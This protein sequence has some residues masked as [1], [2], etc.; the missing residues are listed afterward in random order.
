MNISTILQNYCDRYHVPGLSVAA[1]RDG[2]TLWATG[3]GRANLEW[4]IPATAETVYEI[5]S[6][7]KLFTA[8]AVLRLA[9][10][11][12]LGLDDALHDHLPHLPEAWRGVTIRHCLAHQSGL[13]SYTATE[14]YWQTTRLDVSREELLGYV[15]DLPLL[16]PPGQRYHYDNTGF[17]LLGLLIEQVSGQSY[18]DFVAAQILRPLG[19]AD[20]RANDPY[21]IVSR[22]AQGYSYDAEQAAVRHKPYYSPTGTYSAGVLLSTVADLAKF[23]C[24]LESDAWLS[25]A[26][27]Q[28]MRTIHPSAEANERQL[29][30][31][32]GLGWFFVDHP[33]GRFMG[34]NGGI[35]GFASSFIHLLNDGLTLILLCN[36]DKA[37][38]PHEVLFEVADAVKG[39]S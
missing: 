13:P 11:G 22:R 4:D 2:Q 21:A 30:F 27:R 38:E 9:E 24:A 16:A 1:V 37:A 6:I 23:A 20:S 39:M 17:Y 29:N 10:T 7:T 35:Q 15:A 34:H 3:H 33:R 28:L 12:Q 18:G 8:T 26:S 5:A 32:V 19:M 36:Q 31:S 14:K 25:A